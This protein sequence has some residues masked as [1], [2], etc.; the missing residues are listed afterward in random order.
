[1]INLKVL[2]L[3]SG[4]S[5]TDAQVK[6]LASIDRHCLVSVGRA[7]HLKS[8]HDIGFR[9]GAEF[10]SEYCLRIVTLQKRND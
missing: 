2:G 1:M 10:S 4:E 5:T 7:E 8:F 9:D 3:K 6:L